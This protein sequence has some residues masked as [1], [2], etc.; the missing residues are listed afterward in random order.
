M[1]GVVAVCALGVL[2]GLVCARAELGGYVQPSTGVVWSQ[3]HKGETGSWA[4]WPYAKA[5]AA[6]YQVVDSD[7]AGNSTLYSDWRLPTIAELQAAIADG[8]I[9][10]LIP[11]NSLGRPRYHGKV[12]TWSSESRSKKFAWAVT[13]LIDA[14]GRVIGGGEPVLFGTSSAFDIWFVRP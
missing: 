14:D 3:S 4:T 9:E 1:R 10:Q 12:Y 2:V 8:T 11:R 5:R 6:D 13:L 7:A